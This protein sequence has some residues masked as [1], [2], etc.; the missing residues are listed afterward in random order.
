VILELDL[1]VR[2][3]TVHLLPGILGE[4]GS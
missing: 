2:K 1:E 3:M 4:E